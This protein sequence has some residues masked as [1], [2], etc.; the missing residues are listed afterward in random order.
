MQVDRAMVNGSGNC[1]VGKKRLFD[2]AFK[3]KDIALIR[4]KKLLT[5]AQQSSFLF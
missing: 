1:R 4:L 5:E 2:A 3:L